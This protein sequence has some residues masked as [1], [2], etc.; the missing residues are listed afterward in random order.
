M[1]IGVNGR[2]MLVFWITHAIPPLRLVNLVFD[3]SI[4]ELG[5][6]GIVLVLYL[7]KQISAIP[8]MSDFPISDHTYR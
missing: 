5:C 3:E 1:R 4:F 7:C 6:I 2:E 8:I